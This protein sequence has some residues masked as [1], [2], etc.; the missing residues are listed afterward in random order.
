MRDTMHEAFPGTAA[1]C[2]AVAAVTSG[3]VVHE[4]Y[5][6]RNPMERQATGL[7]AFAHPSG[8]MTVEAR[9]RDTVDDVLVERASFGRTVRLLMHGQAYVAAAEVRR[10]ATTLSPDE[11]TR[12]AVPAMSVSS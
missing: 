11:P 2:T 3:T 8:I 12:R 4:L 1:C 10:L 5:G 7:V 9:V 6:R